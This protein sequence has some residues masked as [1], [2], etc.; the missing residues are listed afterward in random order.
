MPFACSYCPFTGSKEDLSKHI[1]NHSNSELE[2]TK[3]YKWCP[4]CPRAESFSNVDDFKNHVAKVHNLQFCTPEKL[5][6]AKEKDRMLSNHRNIE[7]VEILDDDDKIPEKLEC[8]DG[9]EFDNKK[10][11]APILVQPRENIVENLNNRPY[12]KQKLSLEK[13]DNSV[14]PNVASVQPKL[15]KSSIDENQ[16]HVKSGEIIS[17]PC[18]PKLIKDHQKMA[19]LVLPIN[20]SS[21]QSI[22]THAT[23]SVQKPLENVPNINTETENEPSSITIDRQYDMDKNVSKEVPSNSNIDPKSP[24]TS[25]KW[26]CGQCDST[27]KNRNKLINHLKN[28]K[29]NISVKQ[30]MICTFKSCSRIGIL[31]HMEKSHVKS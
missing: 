3:R 28:I 6:I 21:V 30:C 26:K 14:V 9:T 8:N 24:V 25:N 13:E 19:G 23:S 31:S 5:K 29:E 11:A 17:K 12:K 1:K 4:Y 18:V 7:I 16:L 2:S 10:P 20:N 15:I 27:F 22:D